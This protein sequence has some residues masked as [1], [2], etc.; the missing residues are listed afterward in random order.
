MEQKQLY[1]DINSHLYNIE[2]SISTQNNLTYANI[3]FLNLGKDTITAVKLEAKAFN[4]F[5]EPVLI[6]G[7]ESFYLLIQD[8]SVRKNK[9]SKNIELQLPN[10]DIR[11]LESMSSKLDIDS[12]EL[13]REFDFI[14]EKQLVLLLNLT[15]FLDIISDM[16]KINTTNS[17]DTDKL[18]EEIEILINDSEDAR[19]FLDNTTTHIND[20][21][22]HVDEDVNDKKEILLKNINDE[23]DK[24]VK[25]VDYYHHI[26]DQ[27][28]K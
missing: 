26:H 27:E 14:D 24:I 28:I 19:T 13:E 16:N 25:I 4:A 2:A 22:N 9:V 12:K 3:T 11:R 1:I 7:K 5:N 23:Y 8:I 18:N 17:K 10:N 21:K 6:N 20:I 15:N